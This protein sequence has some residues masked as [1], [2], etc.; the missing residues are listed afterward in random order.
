VI[1]SVAN[2]VELPATIVSLS[3]EDNPLRIFAIER[4]ASVSPPSSTNALSVPSRD[5]RPPIKMNASNLIT[6]F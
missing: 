6:F 5:E 2:W 3:V 1:A 4:F